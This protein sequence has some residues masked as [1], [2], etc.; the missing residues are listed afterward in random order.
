MFVFDLHWL[1][2]IPVSLALYFLLWVLWNLH[3]Q[4]RLSKKAGAHGFVS[5]V[6][7]YTKGRFS[8]R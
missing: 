2:L 7:Q 4:S 6:E 3:R 5:R 8:I 1:A